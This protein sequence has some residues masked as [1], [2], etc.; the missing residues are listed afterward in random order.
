MRRVAVGEALADEDYDRLVEDI[1]SGE[2]PRARPFGLEQLPQA[3]AEDPSVRLVSIQ[4]PEHVNALES[5][6]PLTF[7]PSGLTI[8]YGD[9]AS[10]KSGY[11]RLLKR[12]TRARHQEEVLTDVFRDTAIEKPKALLSVRIE[13]AEEALAWPEA[14]RPELQ[15]MLF[16]D[17]ACGSAYIATE[18]DFPYRPSALFVMDGLIEACVAIRSRIDAKLAENGSAANELPVVSEELQDTDAARFL[19]MLSGDTLVEDLDLLIRRFDES[20]DPIEALKDQ[21]ARLRSADTSKERQNLTRQS[22]KLDALAKHLEAVHAILKAEALAALQGQRET[23]NTLDDAGAVLARTFESEPLRDVGSSP[24]RALWEAARRFSEEH[25]YPGHAFPV[26]DPDCRCVLCQQNLTD[27]GRKR[28]S[29][30]DRFVKDD[31]QVRLQEARRRYDDQVERLGS[32]AVVPEAVATNLGDLEATHADLVPATREFLGRYEAL[33]SS[34]REALRGSGEIPGTELDPATVVARIAEASRAA[35]AAAEVLSN[36]EVVQGQLAEVTRRR[37]ELELLQQ[38]KLSREVIVKEIARLKEREALE[39]AKTAAA[40]GPIT[41]KINELSEESITEVVRDTFTRETDRLRLERVTIART[42]ADK[43]TLLHQPK[44][45]GARQQVPLPRVFSEGERTALGLA[46][47]FT[48]AHLDPSNS[49]IILDDPVTSLDHIRRGLVAGRLAALAETRQVVVFTHDVSFVL[50]LKKAAKADNILVT[51][52]SVTRSRA[53]E[54]K[55]GACG[56]VHPWRA[57]DVPARLEELRSELARIKREQATWDQDTYEKEVGSL[58]GG[59]SQTWERIFSQEIV[60]QVLA[61]G[62]LE[63]R[64]MMVRVLARFS[65]DDYTEFDA[66][67]SRVSQWAKRHDQSALRNYVPPEVDDL[68]QEL[69]LVDAWFKRVKGYK[70]G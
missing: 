54:R 2:S 29:R 53:D 52:R 48:E 55:P 67:Y 12:I 60:G 40:H 33:Q 70:N 4:Q 69:D 68:E 21:E 51:E 58:A 10:G 64:P 32:F 11:A 66:S 17:G 19:K 6:D 30:F 63:V 15:R 23:V 8:V 25:A 7:E 46:A 39:A 43:G 47:F 61:E 37:M 56:T 38:I 34:A 5:K 45:V 59:L 16:Y 35:T 65:D 3:A 42:R 49:A 18:S 14:A 62:G 36:P 22:Q 20:P 28:L 57:K 27:D 9:N 31:T 1:V 50:D 44:L 24:W 13:D 26:V 41:K